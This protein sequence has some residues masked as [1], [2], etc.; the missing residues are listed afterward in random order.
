MRY[1][2]DGCQVASDGRVVGNHACMVIMGL[3]RAMWMWATPGATQARA[4]AARG[5]AAIYM[6]Q[7]C[8]DGGEEGAT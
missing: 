8:V 2:V 3:G 6:A 5:A 1:V 4:V 7:A